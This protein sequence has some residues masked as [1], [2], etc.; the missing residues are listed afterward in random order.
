LDSFVRW[1]QVTYTKSMTAALI[2]VVGVASGCMSIATNTT[3]LSDGSHLGTPYSGT[4]NDL[5]TLVCFGRDVSRNASGL[6]LVPLMLFPLIDVPLSFV[7][8]TLLLPVDVVLE[9]DRP[10]LKIGEGGCRL[11]GM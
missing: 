2:L 11:I 6:L 10:P 8:D 3:L 1:P 9:P 5:H 7:V 4:R